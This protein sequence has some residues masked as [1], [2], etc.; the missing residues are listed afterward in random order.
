MLKIN[1]TLPFISIRNKVYSP[2]DSEEKNSIQ[3][4]DEFIRKT[5]FYRLKYIWEL[6]K[7]ELKITSIFIKNIYAH[8]MLPFML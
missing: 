6:K 2:N 4:H 5:N 3:K 1:K 8:Y 7:N